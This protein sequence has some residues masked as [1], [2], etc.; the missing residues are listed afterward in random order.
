M[1]EININWLELYLTDGE[2][3]VVEASAKDLNAINQ[4]GA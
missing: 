2:M 1:S 3:A 4:E